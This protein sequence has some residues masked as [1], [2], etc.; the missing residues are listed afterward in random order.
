[1]SAISP[2][3]AWCICCS[4]LSGILLATESADAFPYTL[5]SP[6]VLTG[7]E[8]GN[9]GIVGSLLPVALG[10]AMDDPLGIQTGDSSFAT[11]DV[12]V[13]QIALASGSTSVDQIQITTTSNP[14]F[15]NPVGAGVF[16]DLGDQAPG[17][18]S[19]PGFGLRAD[20]GFSPQL[21]E[22]GES[23]TRL[24]VTYTPTGSSLAIGQTTSITLSSGL[25]FTV[26]A[27]IV[28]EPSTGLLLWF[29]LT[30]GA[31]LCRQRSFPI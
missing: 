9:P 31:A 8:T 29:G 16:A 25:D 2:T 18:V 3:L 24:F 23:S 21:L 15:G 6:V 20:F 10:S 1:M 19:I 17:S 13:L 7:S 22:A 11:N 26:Q 14:F 30:C 12:L 4:I 27:T 28:P 5:E